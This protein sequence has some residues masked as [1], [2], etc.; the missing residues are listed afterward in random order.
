M[1]KLWLCNHTEM[2]FC[3]IV[4]RH[5]LL[6]FLYCTVLYCVD[7]YEVLLRRHIF[8]GHPRSLHHPGSLNKKPVWF[9]LSLLMAISEDLRLMN[10]VLSFLAVTIHACGS[11][12]RTLHT[13]CCLWVNVLWLKRV[14][15]HCSFTVHFYWEQSRKHCNSESFFLPL[16]SLAVN[17]LYTC[18]TFM[19]ARACVQ[20]P[21][22]SKKYRCL[23]KLQWNDKHSRDP[24]LHK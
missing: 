10:A 16:L 22:N 15:V 24:G 17:S 3:R 9:F 6:F 13:I 11:I 14:S 7:L 23:K 2:K 20:Y 12:K 1:V 8:V 4:T 18:H 21:P 19:Y 5:K